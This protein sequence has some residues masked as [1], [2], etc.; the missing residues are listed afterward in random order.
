MTTLDHLAGVLSI[1][2]CS[3]LL[4]YLYISFQIGRFI[5]KRY[6]QETDLLDSVAFKEHA[7]FTRKIPNFISLALYTSHLLMC[8]WGWRFYSKRKAF[9][10]IKDPSYVTRHFSK[11]EI[12][13]AKWFAISGLIIIIHCVTYY[14]FGSIW[15]EVFD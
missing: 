10:D 1:S 9:R 13:Q 14:I 11:K 6:E 5:I 4:F 12:R 2:A 3:W 8:I 7:T 15:P